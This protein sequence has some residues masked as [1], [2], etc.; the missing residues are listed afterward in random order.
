V[1]LKSLIGAGAAVLTATFLSAAP[2]QAAFISSD[3]ELDLVGNILFADFAAGGRVNFEPQ[4]ALAS[5]ATGDFDA[6][7]NTIFEAG[8]DTTFTMVD[9]LDFANLGVIYFNNDISFEGIEVVSFDNS[10]NPVAGFRARGIVNAT[11]F[12][13][14]PG[15]FSL[16]VQDD[17]VEVSFSSTTTVIPLPASVFMLLAGLGGLGVVSRRRSATA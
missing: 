10:A 1:K 9:I 16:S 2:A 5:R 3:S 8:A 14:T 11:G 13:P 4:G 12:D 7:V 6:L 17:K 15:F